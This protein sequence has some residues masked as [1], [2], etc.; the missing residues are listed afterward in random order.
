MLPKLSSAKKKNTLVYR[1]AGD[2][3]NLHQG[4]HKLIFLTN[5]IDLFKIKFILKELL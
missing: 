2:D 4:D 3:K 5:F 1:N